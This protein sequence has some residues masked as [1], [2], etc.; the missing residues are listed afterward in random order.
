MLL[1]AL[2]LLTVVVSACGGTATGIATATPVDA[3]AVL[4][5]NP[6]TVILD[7]RTPEE[8]TEAR[9][10]GATNIDFYAPDFADQIA[11]LDRD[12]TYL[13]YCRSGNRSS[14]SE[15]VFQDLGFTD[16][17]MVDG[18]IIAW[19]NAGLPIEQ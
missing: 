11:E 1:A 17:H 16:V 15:S 4:S 18:G 2:S 19:A 12:A 14:Q 9:I 7:I 6:N 5:D 3:S 10:P 13:V 8:V